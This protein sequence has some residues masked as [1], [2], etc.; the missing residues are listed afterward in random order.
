[1]ARI[2]KDLKIQNIPVSDLA[3]STLAAKA[4]VLLAST[5]STSLKANFLIKKIRYNLMIEGLTAGEGPLAVVLAPGDAT[6]TE[7]AA[8]LTEINTVG[9]ED[10]TQVATEDNA[11]V[12][13][14]QNTYMAFR[15]SGTANEMHCIGE[16]DIG[17]G[18]AAI[19][20]QGVAVFLVN[21]DGTVLTTGANVNGLVQLYG[22]WLRD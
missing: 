6:A 4:A 8:A 2:P 11:W 16:P 7:V 21:H 5:F 19:Q 3:L 12:F 9:P 10:T 1:M 20:E 15:P 18:F 17:R 13:A 22:V 14:S